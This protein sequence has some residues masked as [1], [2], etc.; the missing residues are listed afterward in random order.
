[1][2][3]VQVGKRII[4]AESPVTVGWENIGKVEGGPVVKRSWTT[5]GQGERHLSLLRCP[6]KD[7]T[8]ARKRGG[9]Q[10]VLVQLFVPELGTE[11]LIC[12]SCLRRPDNA[13]AVFPEDP[14]LLPWRGGRRVSV[15][16]NGRKQWKGSSVASQ[17][18]GAKGAS[19]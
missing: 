12:R 2:A 3:G 15:T 10:G 6:H 14:Y 18:K 8:A 11:G 13:S 16:V 1:M 7:C 17:K 4:G 5:L 19:K 9:E